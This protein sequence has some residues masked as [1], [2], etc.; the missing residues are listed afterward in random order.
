MVNSDPE[1][2]N[3]DEPISIFNRWP[4]DWD[5]A[6]RLLARG[7]FV[8]SAAQRDGAI[9]LVEI[10]SQAGGTVRLANPWNAEV[11][12]YRNG[13]QAEALSGGVLTIPTVNGETVVLVPRGTTAA[14]V[15]VPVEL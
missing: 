5:A 6:F 10:V 8:I 4:K 12:A 13:R 7:A 14:A 15:R 1:S 3:N 2:V 9:P 11:T